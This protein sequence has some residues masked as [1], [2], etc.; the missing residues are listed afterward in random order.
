MIKTKKNVLEKKKDWISSFALVGET[1][2]NDYTYKINEKSEKS[3]W[4]YNALNLGIY[5]GEK[6]GTVY[7]E[8]MGGYGS[9][10][11][12]VIYVHGKNANG[13]DDFE[14]RF[15]VDWNDRFNT[16]ILDSVGDLC[17][18]TVGLEK[19]NNGKIY[20]KK[21]LTNYDMIAYIYENLKEGMTVNIKGNLK[22]STYNDTTQVRKEINSIVLSKIDDKSKYYANFTQTMLI[23]KNSID[24]IQKDTGIL[25]IYAKVLD[26]TK[27]YNGKEVK[28]NVPYQK[29]FEYEFDLSNQEKVEKIISKLFKVK[30]G[31]TEITFEGDLIEGGSLVQTTESD[32]PDDIKELIDIDVYTLEEVLTKC[33]VNSGREKRMVI[34]KPLVKIVEDEN[35]N[36]FPVIQKFENK[37]DEEDLILDFMVEPENEEKDNIESDIN[38]DYEDIFTPDDNSWLDNL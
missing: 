30:K 6:Y 36:K 10:R 31:V 8:L 3:D 4:I 19:D 11:N 17:F 32:I 25:P 2:I 22:Y 7:V 18:L 29:I 16:D 9:E 24:K 38:F 13:K 35:G 5:C 26:Y 21:F 14:N 23:T 28:T 34:R 12:N 20:Y 1:K 15:T 33:T 37:Y 27:E